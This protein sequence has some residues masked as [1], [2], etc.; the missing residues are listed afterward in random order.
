MQ[1][2]HES[3]SHISAVV[4]MCNSQLEKQ[5][6]QHYELHLPFCLSQFTPYLLHIDVHNFQTRITYITK[7]K[8]LFYYQNI[9]WK[10]LGKKKPWFLLRINRSIRRVITKDP[11]IQKLLTFQK[12]RTAGLTDCKSEMLTHRS[13]K[14]VGTIQSAFTPVQLSKTAVTTSRLLFCLTAN[15]CSMLSEMFRNVIIALGL[16]YSGYCY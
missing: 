1:M 11:H 7:G 2:N 3:H 8:R 6:Y 10:I 9:T 12:K 13:E 15:L 5:G 4:F 16:F 14:Q